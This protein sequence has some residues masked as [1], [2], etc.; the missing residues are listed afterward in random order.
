MLEFLA[1]EFGA[2]VLREEH[3]DGVSFF[4]LPLPFYH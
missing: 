1:T 2:D 4:D 3:V